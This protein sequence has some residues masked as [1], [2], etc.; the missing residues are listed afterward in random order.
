MPKLNQKRSPESH[1]FT[2]KQQFLLE[3]VSEAAPS[4]LNHFRKA[5]AHKSLRS[6][7]TAKCLE[8]VGFEPAEIRRCTGSGCPLYEVRPYQEARPHRNA[9][10]T[11]APSAE[12]EV[13]NEQIQV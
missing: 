9:E 7:I 6:A 3:Q 11:N 10:N 5:Y 13:S 4:K 12:A 1:V 8:C 2:D